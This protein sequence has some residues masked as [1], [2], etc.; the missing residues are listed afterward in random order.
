MD[1]LEL[2]HCAVVYATSDISALPSGAGGFPPY[3]HHPV[4]SCEKVTHR[5]APLRTITHQLF[6]PVQ[7]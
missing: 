2:H 1:A 3:H 5:Y 6:F 7:S 4:A